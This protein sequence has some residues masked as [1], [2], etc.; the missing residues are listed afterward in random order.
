MPLTTYLIVSAVSAA[1]LL[2]SGTLLYIFQTELLYPIRYRKKSRQIPTQEGIPF[3]EETLITK[4]NFKI[5]T[6]I[7]K[8]STDEEASQRPT[9]LALPGNRGNIGQRSIIVSKFYYDFKCN[10]VLLSYRGYGHS[11]GKPTEKGIRIDVQT[12]L[13]YIKRHS[14]LKNTKLIIYGRSLGGAVAIDLVSKNE[15]KIDA[16]IVENTFLSIPK[17]LP[18]FFSPLR[19]F[20]FFCSQIWPSE[21]SICNIHRIPILF[22]SSDKDE[23]VPKEHMKELYNLTNTQR[24]KIWKNFPNGHHANTINQPGY[25][26]TIEKILKCVVNNEE[27]E[28]IEDQNLSQ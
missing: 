28:F 20:T 26:E 24:G 2:G 27:I 8:R 22:L 13:D 19:Y 16:M 25:F 5:K 14:V 9:I 4:D 6:Y 18:T 21:K 12:C 23:L 1:F 15:E 11:E 7:C 3:R 10:I 17:L